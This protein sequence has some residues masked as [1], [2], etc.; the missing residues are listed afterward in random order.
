[1]IL[2]PEGAPRARCEKWHRK[3]LAAWGV[4][5]TRSDSDVLWKKWRYYPLVAVCRSDLLHGVVPMTERIELADQADPGLEA[6]IGM[7]DVLAYPDILAGPEKK[8]R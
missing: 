8:P 1:M 6:D 7:L 2:V 3:G 4:G 5:E